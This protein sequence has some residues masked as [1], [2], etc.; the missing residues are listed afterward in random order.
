VNDRDDGQ[1]TENEEFERA[2]LVGI[3]D[4][5]GKGRR[6]MRELIELTKTAG[7]LVV[8]MVNQSRGKPDRTSFIGKGKVEELRLE[9][10]EEDAD[11]AIF[12]G[13]LTPVQNRNLVNSLDQCKVLDRTELI[14]DIFAQ[15]ARSHEGKL[16][17]ELAQLRYT[18]PRLAGKGKML[19]RIRGGTRGGGAIGVRGPGEAK[20][21]VE[22][23][24][25]RR[26]IDRLEEEL[27]EVRHR[28]EVERRS[29][30]KSGMPSAAVVGYTN[31]GKSTLF[32]ALAGSHEVSTRSRLFETLDPT[33]RRIDLDEGR[34]CLISDTVGFI[35]DL[36]H[37]LIAAFRATLEE[38]TSADLLLHVVDASD[39]FALE[40]YQAA[41]EVVEELGAAEIPTI[42]VLNKTDALST[43]RR[44]ERLAR[45]V[46]NTIAV[47]ALTGDGLDALRRRMSD[48]LFV[49]LIPATL[50][51]PYDRMDLLQS[52]HDQGMVVGSEYEEKHVVART[53]LDAATLARVRDY[54]VSA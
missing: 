30:A 40:Q 15:H 35:Q 38:V 18:L 5:E 22:R 42:V 36:P 16:Q 50:H 19:D 20:I 9:V 46:P 39:A 12:N 8:G 27:A 44:I 37:N 31:A 33:T 23:R 6:S 3:E 26:R 34:Q 14:L 52:L 11:L 1:R 51:I 32:N 13:E 21:D 7:A 53:E 4:L 41:Q 49:H 54:V 10:I 24:T 43:P 47:S 45:H 17:V 28:R 48:L 2:I 25:I 29:R